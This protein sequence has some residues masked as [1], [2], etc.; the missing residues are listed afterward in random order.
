MDGQCHSVYFNLSRDRSCSG[1]EAGF[2]T[3]NLFEVF[4]ILTAPSVCYL[5]NLFPLWQWVK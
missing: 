4:P 2:V 3:I 1:S 5:F